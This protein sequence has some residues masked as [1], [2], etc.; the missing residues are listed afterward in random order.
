[1]EPK[2]FR[3]W[4]PTSL[5]HYSQFWGT[6]V[7]VVV[8]YF[9]CVSLGSQSMQREQGKIL[10]PYCAVNAAAGEYAQTVNTTSHWQ[11]LFLLTSAVFIIA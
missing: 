2:W 1:M 5:D 6:E 3:R 7:L 9:S 11:E 4:D 10:G 8:A